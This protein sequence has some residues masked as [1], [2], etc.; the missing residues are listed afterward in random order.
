M[1]VGWGRGGCVGGVRTLGNW[2]VGGL[3]GWGEGEA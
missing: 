3:R 1:I 2:T